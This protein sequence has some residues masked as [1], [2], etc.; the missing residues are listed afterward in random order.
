M[1]SQSEIRNVWRIAWPVII[2][3]VLNVLVGLVDLRMVG[4]LGVTEIAA[5]GMGRQVM[6]LV[7]VIM[8]AISGGSSVV[9]ARAHGAGDIKGISST[10]AKSLVYMAFTAVVFVMP[11]GIL[12]DR[13]FLVALGGAPEVVEL[14]TSYLNVIFLGSLFTMFNFGVSGVLLGV[15]RTRV[16]LVLLLAV[17]ALNIGLN[18]LFIFGAGPVPAMGIV[19][20]AWGTFVSRG[21][22]TLAGIWIVM[23]PRFGVTAR[24]RDGFSI[25]TRLMGQIIRLGGPRSLQGIVRNF[26]RLLTIR[27]ITLLA[28]ATAMVSAYSVGMQVRMIS[29]FVGL[30]FMQA[31]AV[32]VGFNMGAERPDEAERSGWIAAGLAAALMTVVAVVMAIIPEQIMGFFTNDESVIALGR[33]FFVVVALSEPIMAFALSIGGA[34]RG[35]GDSI[36]PFVYGSISDLLVVAAAGYLFAVT[37]G[38]GFAGIAAALALSALT[39]AIPTVLKYRQGKWRAIAI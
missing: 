28:G 39:R 15:G 5:V 8:I 23:S 26:S 38:F 4:A 6:N 10:A 7:F 37:L 19:G 25:D 18:Y 30:A 14:G 33:S 17:N 35:G 36:S 21:L 11:L 29:T 16:S 12:T 1:D 22:G 2:T 3:N 9:I 24:L 20:A 13:A 32:R 34:L 27:V 31:A